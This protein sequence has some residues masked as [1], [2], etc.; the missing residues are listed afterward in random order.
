MKLIEVL[1]L[2][3]TNKKCKVYHEC[4]AMDDKLAFKGTIKDLLKQTYLCYNGTL[5]QIIADD[6]EHH[7]AFILEN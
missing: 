6:F 4:I 1:E 2:L 7:I 5:F 3:S